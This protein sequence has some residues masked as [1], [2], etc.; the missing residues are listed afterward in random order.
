MILIGNYI[1]RIA[2]DVPTFEEAWEYLLSKSESVLIDIEE[3]AEELVKDKGLSLEEAYVEADEEMQ[4]GYS[5]TYQAAVL[6]SEGAI[7]GEDIHRVIE[8]PADADPV[9]L[10]KLGIY[11][12]QDPAGAAAYWGTGEEETFLFRAR[13]DATYVN[14]R[15]LVLAR[16]INPDEDEITY[17]PNSPIFV[18]DVELPN[19]T[20]VPINDWRRV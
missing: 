2:N 20:V 1:Y 19:G 13:A 5:E 14:A 18:Y 15:E 7:T 6:D 3:W 11:W 9:D 12:A 4:A 8:L 10:K 17:L 16:M